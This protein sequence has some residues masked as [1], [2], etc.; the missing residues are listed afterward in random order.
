MLEG[1][2]TWILKIAHDTKRRIGILNIVIRHLLALNLTSGSK[3][4]RHRLESAVEL[5]LLMRILTIAKALLEVKLQEEFLI[6]TSLFA[7]IGSDAAVVFCRMRI[8]FG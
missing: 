2:A 1:N 7:H 3:R 6:Q 4:E 5:S 8:G